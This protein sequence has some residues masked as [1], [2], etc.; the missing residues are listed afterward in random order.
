MGLSKPTWNFL[1]EFSSFAERVPG[2]RLNLSALE[3]EAASHPGADLAIRL[4]DRGR[5]EAEAT[6]SKQEVLH[7]GID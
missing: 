2:V 6:G 5:A 3:P 4:M 1:S 7:R